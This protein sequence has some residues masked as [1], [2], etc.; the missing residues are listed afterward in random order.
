MPK[1][2]SN[3]TKK[4]ALIIGGI[5]L[6]ILVIGGLIRGTD[7]EE[8][9]ATKEENKTQTMS[10]DEAQ[11]KCMLMEEADLVNYMGE[12]FGDATTK[13]ASDFCL[14]LWDMTKN[15]DNTE[16]KF[17]ETVKSDWEQRKNEVLEGYTLQQLYDES[18]EI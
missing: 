4:T 18:K 1:K 11:T 6:V 5:I 15:P 8:A 2:E 14:S 17:I 13:K 12:P 9:P 3:S 7:K 10:I 16:E